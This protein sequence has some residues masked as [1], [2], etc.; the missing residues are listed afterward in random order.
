MTYTIH[1]LVSLGQSSKT[2]RIE[3]DIQNLT[4]AIKFVNWAIPNTTSKLNV[5]ESDGVSPDKIVCVITRDK[6]FN[7]TRAFVTPE[8]VEF[9]KG[10]SSKLFTSSAGLNPPRELAEWLITEIS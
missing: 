7:P 4:E 3:K 8:P 10:N 9:F 6:L 5:V 2:L 1:I